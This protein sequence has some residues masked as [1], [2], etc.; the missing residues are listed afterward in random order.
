MTDTEERQNNPPPLY[1]LYPSASSSAGLGG[2]MYSQV[3]APRCQPWTHQPQGMCSSLRVPCGIS[4]EGALG[5]KNSL[6]SFA[7]AACRVC[8]FLKHRENVC[9]SCLWLPSS[10]AELNALHWKNQG[11]QDVPE[12]TSKDTAVQGATSR[13]T[14]GIPHPHC[15]RSWW[16]WERSAPRICSACTPCS[17]CQQGR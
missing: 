3:T 2:P 14:L 11:R 13:V 4:E 16:I 8:A 6:L 15:T 9:R 5:C 17:R 12:S 7:A 10:T 1:A